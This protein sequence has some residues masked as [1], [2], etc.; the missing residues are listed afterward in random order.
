M[1]APR[2]TRVVHVDG[3]EFRV[4]R[5]SFWEWFEEG[6]EPETLSVFQRYLNHGGT[7][8]DVGAYVGPTVL[9]AAAAGATRIEAVE[10]NP[11]TF[12]LLE[13]TLE[14]NAIA[15]PPTRLHF[16]CISTVDNEEVQMSAGGPV[17]STSSSIN[18]G[19]AL[20]EWTV[21]SILLS[22]FLRETGFAGNGLVKIDI[23]GAESVITEDIRKV[24]EYPQTAVHL[25]LHP[26]FWGDKDGAASAILN[27]TRQFDVFDVEGSPLSRETLQSMMLTDEQNPLW[28]TAW[29]N[30]FEVVLESKA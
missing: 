12:R 19:E 23:E 14:Y 4:A 10:A 20:L 22:T 28:G 5:N 9:Y 8:V 21:P 30:F 3:R 29:G 27:M 7:F 24:G 11:V 25:S 18:N 26:P 1:N 2:R 16:R 13:S 15:M 6:W 17:D